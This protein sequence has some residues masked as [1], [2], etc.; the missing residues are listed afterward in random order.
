MSAFSLIYVSRS[1]LA[2][3]EAEAAIADIISTAVERN[4]REGMTGA[5]LYSGAHFVQILEGPEQAVLQLM[6]GIRRDP[7]H[8]KV[9]VLDS[10]ASAERMFE[11]WSMAYLGDAILVRSHVDDLLTARDDPAALAAAVLRMRRLMREFVHSSQ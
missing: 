6:A 9:D 11:G 8:T 10:L 4:G 1:L 5:L 3:D 2:S 7:R